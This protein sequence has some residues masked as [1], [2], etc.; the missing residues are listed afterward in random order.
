MSAHSRS[1]GRRGEL[2]A[3][4]LLAEYGIDGE[5]RYGQEER[6]GGLGDIESTA[7][8]WEVKRRAGLPEWLDIAEGVRG[9]LVRRDR[10]QWLVVLRAEDFLGLARK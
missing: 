1:K 8:N 6:G 10:G 9:V 2:E 5:I 3:L 4:A 7:G